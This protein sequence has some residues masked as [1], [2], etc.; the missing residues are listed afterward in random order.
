MKSKTIILVLVLLV[1]V[2]AI[3]FF[4]KRKPEISQEEVQEIALMSKQEKAKT[5][6]PAKEISSPDAFINVREITLG[7]LVGKEVI[8][9]DFWTYSCINCQRTLPYL[10]D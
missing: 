3:I 6:E 4:E 1:V 7:E 9:V 5:Y 10:N 2:V 8:L